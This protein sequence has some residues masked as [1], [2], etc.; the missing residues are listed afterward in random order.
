MVD[1]PS[2]IY[3]SSPEVT[4]PQLNFEAVT[5]LHFEEPSNAANHPSPRAIILHESFR[6]RGRVH[7]LV[8][9]LLHDPGSRKAGSA[10]PKPLRK[11][12]NLREIKFEPRAVTICLRA[13]GKGAIPSEA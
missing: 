5:I 12:F 10:L 1:L 11:I 9:W 7:W 2:E 8:G 13:D 3:K 6:V 4:A